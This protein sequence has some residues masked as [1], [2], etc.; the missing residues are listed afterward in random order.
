M[1]YTKKHKK[2][3]DNKSFFKIFGILFCGTGYKKIEN[4]FRKNKNLKV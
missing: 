3:K 2:K 1:N 4:K